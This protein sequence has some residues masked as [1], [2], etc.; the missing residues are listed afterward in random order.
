MISDTF[1]NFFMLLDRDRFPQVRYLFWIMSFLFTPIAYL[2][3]PYTLEGFVFGLPDFIFT[4]FQAFYSIIIYESMVQVY[5]T[6][7]DTTV[8]REYHLTQKEKKIIVLVEVLCSLFFL[9]STFLPIVS[10]WFEYRKDPIKYHSSPS[11]E[12]EYHSTFYLG[13]FFGWTNI[14]WITFLGVFIAQVIPMS[15]WTYIAERKISSKKYNLFL[16]R[17]LGILITVLAILYSFDSIPFA[18]LNPV[19]FR[20]MVINLS[21]YYLFLGMFFYSFTLSDHPENRELVKI[22]RNKAFASNIKRNRMIF[23]VSLIYIFAIMVFYEIFDLFA[24]GWIEMFLLLPVLT[25]FFINY[26]TRK[27]DLFKIIEETQWI[28]EELKEGEGGKLEQ[29]AS[30]ELE[31]EG[32]TT[33][34]ELEQGELEQVKLE[35][36]ANGKQE[37]ME[38]TTSKRLK[39]MEVV[40]PQ[41]EKPA[42]E[43]YDLPNYFIE[44]VDLSFIVEFVQTHKINFL[45]FIV[46]F[47]ISENQVRSVSDLKKYIHLNPDRS[48]YRIVDRLEKHGYLEKRIDIGDPR[49]KTIELLSKG[50]NL[51]SKYKEEYR[52]FEE[53]KRR[54]LLDK[55]KIR[56][57]LQN[58]EFVID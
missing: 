28:I 23:N 32:Q 45:D 38:Q 22:F 54:K 5:R 4:I 51:V 33:N 30:G 53:E 47:Y 26:Y 20:T 8:V 24:F 3:L 35:Q 17:E 42:G 57:S 58:F 15:I 41:M 7:V 46:L 10:Q 14:I 31:H 56:Q 43:D 37:P 13:P 11:F 19:F 16:F 40:I 18:R 48:I 2:I 12:G 50:E 27:I 44:N 36:E 1:E 21:L 25:I 52:R 9:Y 39:G 34:E 6:I 49:T 55:A 29:E